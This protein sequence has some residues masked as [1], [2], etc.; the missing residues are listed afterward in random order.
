MKLSK[1]STCTLLFHRNLF[2]TM[3]TLILNLWPIKKVFS[4]S[5]CDVKSS[6][7][8]GRFVCPLICSFVQQFVSCNHFK[9]TFVKKDIKYTFT[10]INHLLSYFQPTISTSLFTFFQCITDKNMHIDIYFSFHRINARMNNINVKQRS[11]VIH[12]I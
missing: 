10:L 7:V 4:R 11:L 3:P 5:N 6:D 8:F 12:C 9:K 2:V 1:H